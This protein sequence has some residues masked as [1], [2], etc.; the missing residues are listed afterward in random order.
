MGTEAMLATT[1]CWEPAP[2]CSL[3]GKYF[4]SHFIAGS[5]RH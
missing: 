2:K 4:Y 5:M 1:M 3:C